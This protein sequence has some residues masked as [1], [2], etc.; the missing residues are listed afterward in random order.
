M[1]KDFTTIVIAILGVAFVA[2]IIGRNAKT[3]EVVTAMGDAF[4]GSLGT[5][6]NAINR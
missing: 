6:V 4:S 2:V 1:G 5:L 3:V